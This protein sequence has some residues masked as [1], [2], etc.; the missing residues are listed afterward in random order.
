MPDKPQKIDLRQMEIIREVTPPI[1]ILVRNSNDRRKMPS[2]VKQH[3]F[4][5][6]TPTGCFINVGNGI[7]MSS[8]EFCFLQMA[9]E[10]SLVE[11][12]ELGY[13][14]CGTYSLSANAAHAE[15]PTFPARGFNIR[16]PL[17]S[18]KKL[19]DF[20][21]GMPGVEGHKKAVR[22][23]RYISDGAASPMEAKLA[24]L[25]TLPYKL[26][27]YHF[28]MPEHNS[29]IVPVKTEKKSAS[30]KSYACD[31]YW[32][33]HGLAIEYDSD[34]YHTG[35][36]RIASDSKRRNAL[37]LMGVTVITVTN[38]QLRNIPELEKVAYALAGHMKKRLRYINPSFSA[39][40]RELHRLLI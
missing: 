29:R 1:H 15:E 30:K 24:I 4:S 18:K 14:L 22:A 21:A 13:E 12:I 6:E 23:L 38:Q 39:A 26:G 7:M 35:P 17:S 34:S 19:E 37:E 25:L 20:I 36:E 11:L 3:I 2:Y 27:G 16:P 33:D 5:M 40:H 8:P 32:P 10:F 31:L 28:P 9:K